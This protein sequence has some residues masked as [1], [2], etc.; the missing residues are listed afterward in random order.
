[1]SPQ[2]TTLSEFSHPYI[3]NGYFKAKINS[4]YNPCMHSIQWL[5]L[6]EA[7]S[8]ILSPATIGVFAVLITV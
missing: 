4:D 2:A 7:S 1:M 6:L 8:V 5:N 3:M